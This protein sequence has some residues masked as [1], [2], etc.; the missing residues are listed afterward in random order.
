MFPFTTE[1]REALK[2]QQVDVDTLE[3]RLDRR[4]P[5]VFPAPDAVSPDV[6]ELLRAAGHHAIHVRDRGM[7]DA[8]DE[9][10]MALA[11]RSG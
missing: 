9:Q 1:L 10:L 5:W 8:A 3:R 2:A 7:A 4:V 6:A 11:V